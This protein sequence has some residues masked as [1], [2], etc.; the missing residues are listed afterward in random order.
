[1]TVELITLVAA[2]VMWGV[3][4]GLEWGNFW[5]NMT[6]AATI[7]AITG[8][9][10]MRSQLQRIFRFRAGHVAIG[11]VSAVVLYVV[12]WVGDFVSA[13]IFPFAV[14]QVGGIYAM[15]T[16]MNPLTISLLLFFL[17]GPAEE[18]FWRGFLQ[19]RFARR[20]GNRVGWIA[21]GFVYAIVHVWSWNF[22]LVMAALICGMFWGWM[23]LRWK[24]L[25]PGIVSHAAWDVLVF[26]ILPIR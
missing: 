25:W 1:M 26:L 15:K 7:L 22:M 4:F 14:D 17:I 9:V 11:L 20:W 21:A 16:Q 6:G 3:M 18:V 13:A 24:S 19:D 23:Y 12:F 8:I 5:L 10:A 2:G